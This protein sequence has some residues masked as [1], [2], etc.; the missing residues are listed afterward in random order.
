MYWGGKS[1]L[2]FQLY[3]PFF[4][5][6][7]AQNGTIGFKTVFSR[8][9]G[10]MKY[11]QELVEKDVGPILEVLDKGGTLMICG[12][13]QMQN[14]VLLILGQLCEQQGKHLN[15]YQ[16]NGQLLMDCY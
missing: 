5:D 14:G 7:K 6:V 1:E 2:S 8:E 12:S 11:V 15:G 3:K 13:V 9:N 16:T 4:E 10:E